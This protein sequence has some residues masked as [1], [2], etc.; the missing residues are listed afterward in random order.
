MSSPEFRLQTS[1]PLFA[2]RTN[3]MT[4]MRH[5]ANRTPKQGET[6]SHRNELNR[7]PSHFFRRKSTA[8]VEPT[9]V[10]SPAPRQVR[11]EL[12][13]RHS[14]HAVCPLVLMCGSSFEESR[15]N[16]SC[17]QEWDRDTRESRLV[18]C[19]TELRFRLHAPSFPHGAEE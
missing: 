14:D 11:L 1:V 2:A 10:R 8:R 19:P 12:R 6:S 17:W 16:S 3:Q 13:C 18:T 4:S 15:D 9:S 7:F 5:L